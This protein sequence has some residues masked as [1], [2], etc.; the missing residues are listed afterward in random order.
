MGTVTDT[1]GIAGLRLTPLRQI[2]DARGAVLHMLRNDAPE[3]RAFGEC[4]FSEVLPRAIKGWKRHLR[5]TQNLAVPVGR[6]R[7]VFFDARDAGAPRVHSLE[8]GRPDAY[9]RLQ[10]PPLLWYG[11]TA[12]SERAA[13]IVNCADLPHDPTESETLALDALPNAQALGLLQ[14]VSPA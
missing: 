14:R 1:G 12:V 5:Q 11:F 3:F 13:L 6:V 2:E 9:L 10:I 4:Y 8:L 7:F